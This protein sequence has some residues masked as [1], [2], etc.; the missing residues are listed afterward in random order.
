M[1]G[2]FTFFKLTNKLKSNRVIKSDVLKIHV[3]LKK[4][5]L[6]YIL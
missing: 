2:Y 5:N 3:T 1:M 4:Y 6:K